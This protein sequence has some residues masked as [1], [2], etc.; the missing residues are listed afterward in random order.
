MDGERREDRHLGAAAVAVKVLRVEGMRDDTRTPDERARAR[1]GRG[2]A[3][4]HERSTRVLDAARRADRVSTTSGPW[5]SPNASVSCSARSR[6]TTTCGSVHK[7]TFVD[8][9]TQ[10][11]ANRLLIQHY[12]SEHPD[13]ARRDH[14]AADRRDRAAR[15]RGAPTSRTCVGADRRLRHLPVYVAAQPAPQ[16]GGGTRARR[17]RSALD[18]CRRRGGSM[19]RQNEIMAAMHEHSPDHAC[20]ENELQIPDFA[21]YQWEWM[22]DGAGL[23]RPLPRARPDAALPVHA[24]R[25]RARSRH[26]FPG[27]RR[28]MLKSNQHS[29]QLGPLLA[30]YPDATVVMIHRD[31]VATLQSLLTMRGLLFKSSQKQSRHR[32]A[33]RLLGRPH[34]AHAPQLRAR[35]RTR[36][37][38]PARR[39]D[40]RRHRQRRRRCAA[41]G[42]SS[43]LVS[44]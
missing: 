41:A 43:G 29:E 28:W 12:W 26:Q 31:P 27:D 42:C 19:M 4:R 40:V 32:R 13:V 33:R 6:P 24:R 16:P 15:G 22:A 35:P 10:A 36:S 30:T 1:S 2:A 44:P 9:C 7:A 25:A 14:R 11:A 17:C 5:T 23:P 21:S 8:Q 38:R 39:G 37:R 18:A 20:G 34:R 3:A